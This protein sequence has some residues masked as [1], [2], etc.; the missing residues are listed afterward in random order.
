MNRQAFDIYTTPHI[1]GATHEIP[2]A[3]IIMEL[4]CSQILHPDVARRPK[5]CCV[6]DPYTKQMGYF[7]TKV[8]NLIY[9]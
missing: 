8:H 3:P 2:H 4:L 9:V 7:M 6:L 1:Y 5:R